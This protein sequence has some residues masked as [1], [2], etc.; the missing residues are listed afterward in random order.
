MLPPSHR[1]QVSHEPSP[2]S[3][4]LDRAASRHPAPIDLTLSNPTRAGL[5]YAAYDAVLGGAAWPALAGNPSAGPSYDPDPLGMLSARE[6]VAESFAHPGKPT[7]AADRVLLLS[8]S[9]EAY[10]YLFLLLCDPGDSVLAP[11]PSY[12][13]FTHLAR[14]AGVR[15]EPYRLDYDGAWHV[16][17][18]S[19]ERAR[20]AS[21]ARAILLVSPNNPTG[22]RVSEP[23]LTRLGGLGLP[24]IC[25][26]VFRRFPFAGRAA[27]PSALGQTDAL[28][29]CIDGLS[30]SAGLPQLKLSW[31]CVSGPDAAVRES[32]SRL[33]WMAD[34]YLSVAS[35]VQSALPGLLRAGESFREP[36]LA[37]LQ[38]NR[39]RLAS[40]LDGSAASLLGADGGWYALVRVPELC[41][42]EDWVLALLE[43]EGVLCH[44][45]HFYDVAG[46]APHL[47]LSLLPAPDVFARGADAIVREIGRRVAL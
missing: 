24:L 11:E 23:E 26:E 14:Y 40:A 25:D 3:I 21:R 9:S 46:R 19:V 18:D 22:S 8:S 43:R 29:F 41:S 20:R 30:K 38:A 2:L 36:L 35:P 13:L 15:L 39:A 34:T 33:S 32:M 37:R 5:S 47:V 12:P 7:L 6:A 10:A 1:S 42:D 27:L 4:A 28:T 44:P 16:D 17:F 31:L 45:G